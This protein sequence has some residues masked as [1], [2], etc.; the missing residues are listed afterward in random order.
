[1]SGPRVEV[2]ALGGT[3]ASVA[4]PGG[5]VSPG[6]T[7]GDLLASVPGVGALA[8]I[9]ARNLANVP[10]TEI[11]PPLLLEVLAAIRAH[12]AEGVAGVVVTQGTD[13]LEESAFFLDLV[14]DG[15]MPVVVTG[16][17]RNPT[18]PGPDGAANLHAAI[19]CAADPAF[20]GQGVLVAFDD[21]IHAAAWV[22]K[23]DTSATGAFGSP[24][25]LGWIAEGRPVMRAPAR[26]RPA[27]AVP[28][29]AAFP[30]APILKPGIGDEPRL[31]GAALEAGAEALVL[32]LAGG[33][34]VAA[35]WLD[36]LDAAVAR[37]PVIF[38][39]RTRGGRVLSRT[40]GQPGAEIDLLRRGLVG[41]GDLDA[42]KARLAIGLLLMAGAPERFGDYADL[43]WNPDAARV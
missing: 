31:V 16:A 19:A 41:S 17:M 29:G 10:S 2:L 20:R 28:E 33:G 5:G 18:L 8:R 14:H 32:D 7:A 26:R 3:I 23:G 4:D 35:C 43:S 12:A 9:G 34:H 13:S 6:L 25:P 36:A 22:R 21:V 24:A 1:M 39:S 40:Y 37:I 11:A 38:A 30:F 15:D 27:I 42:L